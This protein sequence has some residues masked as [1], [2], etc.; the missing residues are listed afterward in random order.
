MLAVIKQ[1]GEG[2]EARY[3]RQFKHPVEKVWSW[4]TENDKLGKWFSGLQVEELRKGGVFKFD[5]GDGNFEILEILELKE[6][7]VLEYTWGED[8]VR[9]ELIPEAGGCHLV[10]IESIHQITDHTHRDLTGW[11]ICLHAID[12]LMDGRDLGDWE[13]EAEILRKQY[14]ELVEGLAS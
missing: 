12:A 13:S 14:A 10:L 1:K 5:L 6:H 11:H 7:Y 4:L 9:F 8:R 3:E 2:Y